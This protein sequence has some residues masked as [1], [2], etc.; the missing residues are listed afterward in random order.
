V[1]TAVED[2]KQRWQASQGAQSI[3]AG[4]GVY[5]EVISR[6]ECQQILNVIARMRRFLFE[7]E[8]RAL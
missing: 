6:P 3:A 8:Q 2:D 4:R 1:V 5:A 7:G